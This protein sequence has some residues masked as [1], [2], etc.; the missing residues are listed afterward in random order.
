[1]NREGVGGVSLVT[2]DDGVRINV[3]VDIDNGKPPLVLSNSLGCDLHM[4][5]GQVEPFRQ[6]FRLI[7][8]DSRGLGKSDAPRG[9]YSIER[10][11]R[12]VLAILDRFGI[13]Q[14]SYCGLSLGGMI[15]QWLGI[16]APDRLTRLALCNTAA[17]VPEPSAF[18]ER[19]AAVRKNGVEPLID[20]IIARWFLEGFRQTHSDALAPIRA[21]LAACDREGYAACCE[22]IAGMD[23]T[24]TI[25]KI[26][27]PTLVLVG[28]GDP[29][30]PPSSAE[31]IHSRIAGS[32]YVVIPNAAHLTNIEQ[33]AA[34]NAAVLG[35]LTGS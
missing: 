12:D 34:F 29:A 25:G 23:E 3:E 35:F 10:L 24:R 30:T 16:N 2:V 31:F 19:A 18:I 13:R 20:G 9:P 4:W 26:G 7:R 33:P 22:A 8:Y 5:D 28:D 6:H 21:T 11:A 17:R 27:T 32:K 1:M 15:G 14:T